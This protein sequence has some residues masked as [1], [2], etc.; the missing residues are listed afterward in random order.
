LQIETK[1]TW[2]K[3]EMPALCGRLTTTSVDEYC[4][5]I[6]AYVATPLVVDPSELTRV[7]VFEVEQQS[8]NSAVALTLFSGDRVFDIEVRPQARPGVDQILLVATPENLKD[9]SGELCMRLTGTGSYQ[10]RAGV[11]HLNEEWTQ[12]IPSLQ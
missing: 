7:F 2:A 3:F 6:S 4:T 5:Q 9:Y 11:T 10:L 1:T 12:A 8:A